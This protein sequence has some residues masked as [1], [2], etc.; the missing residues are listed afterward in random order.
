MNETEARRFAIRDGVK[1]GLIASQVLCL[2]IVGGPTALM[3]VAAGVDMLSSS[4]SD[5]VLAT[6]C[7]M[8]LILLTS[9]PVS[10]AIGCLGGA[11]IGLVS[12][13]IVKR[14]RHVPVLSAACGFLLGGTAGYLTQTVLLAVLFKST[15]QEW[16]GLALITCLL[17]GFAGMAVS[18]EVVR[19]H[20]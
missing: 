14:R 11:A 9:S 1:G 12:H 10:A 8:V 7:S 18:R 15:S 16:G 13:E 2:V 17:T 5:F 6:A 20:P 3:W 19:D 4:G